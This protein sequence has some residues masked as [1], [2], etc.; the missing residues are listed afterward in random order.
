MFDHAYDGDVGLPRFKVLFLLFFG[1]FL[2]DFLLEGDEPRD[3]A[4]G[5]GEGGCR[6]NV[7]GLIDGGKDSSVE[8][9]LQHVFGTHIQLLGELA[10]RDALGDGN[11]AR[12]TRRLCHRLDAGGT[13]LGESGTGANGMQLSFTLFETLLE[14]RASASRRLAFVNGLAR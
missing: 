5:F 12:G 7:Q 11:F 6:G 3:F 9:I 1:Y 8:K 13:A 2:N 14:S 4:E 10:D